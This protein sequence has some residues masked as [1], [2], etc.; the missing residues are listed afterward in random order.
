LTAKQA[1]LE[2]E[3]QETS[4][5]EVEAETAVNTYLAQNQK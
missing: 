4:K 1:K 2:L 5:Q 3:V